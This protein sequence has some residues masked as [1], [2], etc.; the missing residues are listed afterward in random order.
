MKEE[1]RIALAFFDI[2]GTSKRL[3]NNE[4]QKVYEYY[5]QM[6][7]LCSD[8]TI[9]I[10]IE[11]NLYGKSELTKYIGE[12]KPFI[13][14]E[15]ELNNAFFSDTFI[16]WVDVD[17]P[18][19]VLLGSF[20]EKCS[21]IFCEALKRKIPL[22]GTIAIGNSIMD[23]E[24]K[25]Y[26]GQPLVEAAKG[27][28]CQNWIG[29]GLGKSFNMIHTMDTRYI[30]PYTNHIK[31]D[32]NK[33]SELLNP[34]ALDWPR[35]WREQNYGDITSILTNMNTDTEF[36]K[37]Y[38]NCLNF[39]EYSQNGDNIWEESTGIHGVTKQV[40]SDLIEPFIVID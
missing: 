30:L 23:D 1:K 20:F 32:N 38:D 12:Q 39:F 16:I 4:L 29:V 31:A 28:P 17:G 24:K 9:P 25:I 40:L 6:A 15:E 13:I 37:Y 11:N 36:S 19:N 21:I 3:I 26:L 10:I 33:S 22:R 34:F 8:N 27:E 18:F 7:M 5:E 2:L 35:I 14:L